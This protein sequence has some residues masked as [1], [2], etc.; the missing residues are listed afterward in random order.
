M[1]LREEVTAMT[2]RQFVTY[3][4]I[5]ECGSFAERSGITDEEA[6]VIAVNLWPVLRDYDDNEFAENVAWPHFVAHADGSVTLERSSWR[7]VP[8]LAYRP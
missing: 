8:V 4:V 7:P 6:C 3:E 5:A 2:L 1:S